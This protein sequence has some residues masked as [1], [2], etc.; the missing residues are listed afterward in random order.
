VPAKERF[1]MVR[2]AIARLTA[3]HAESVGAL[4]MG[5]AMASAIGTARLAAAVLAVAVLCMQAAMQAVPQFAAA[6]QSRR[7]ESHQGQNGP[8]HIASLRESRV[9]WHGRTRCSGPLSWISSAQSVE[10]NKSSDCA[11][12]AEALAGKESA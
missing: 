6:A 10:S 4:T 1:E 9:V 3:M 2:V 11:Y 7:G 12:P 8:F 5:R